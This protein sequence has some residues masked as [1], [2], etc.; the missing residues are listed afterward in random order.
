MDSDM[1][2]FVIIMA[3]ALG[4]PLVGMGVEKYQIGQC[5][6]EAIRAAMPAEQI[7]KVCK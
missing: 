7:E 6:T 1:K 3:I 4:V 2:W 5:R